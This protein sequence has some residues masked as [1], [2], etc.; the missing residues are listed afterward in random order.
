[1]IKTIKFLG[2]MITFFRIKPTKPIN[3]SKPSAFLLTRTEILLPVQVKFV[4]RSKIPMR[5]KGKQPS[6]K[7]FLIFL[8]DFFGTQIY[9]KVNKLD[10][11]FTRS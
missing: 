8:I 5:R 3:H 1:M 9:D 11:G 6:E 10:N 4:F 7:I 2:H